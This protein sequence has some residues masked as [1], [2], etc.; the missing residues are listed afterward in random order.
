[1]QSRIESLAERERL[2]AESEATLETER[3]RLQVCPLL[4]PYYMTKDK[5]YRRHH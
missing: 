5:A 1:M 4:S 3:W 2:L